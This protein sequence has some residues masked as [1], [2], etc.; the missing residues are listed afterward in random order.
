MN[1]L[2][3]HGLDSSLS[4]E[5]R[6]VL[7]KF[8][9]VFAPHLDYREDPNSIESIMRLIA[10]KEY[11]VVIGSSMG[12]FA[13]YYIADAIQRPSLLFNPALAERSVFQEIPN[14]NNPLSNLK[15]FVLGA[16]DETID[17]KSTLNFLADSLDKNDYNIKIRQ[18]LQ[19][20]IPI[21]IFKEEVKA[22]FKK[23]CL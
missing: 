20:R 1:I 11:N 8:G 22:F 21:E 19:H 13:A 14:F 4:K 6:S 15:H 23:L 17:P 10:D 18:D 16:K 5:K 2:Y 9:S 3:L 7:E 12:G